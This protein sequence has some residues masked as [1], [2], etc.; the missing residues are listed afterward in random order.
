[1][2]ASG[3]AHSHARGASA[4]S[5]LGVTAVWPSSG[6]WP[7]GRDWPAASPVP[8]AA[9]ALDPG[10]RRIDTDSWAIGL[11]AL[12][13]LL[14]LS[15]PGSRLLALTPAMLLLG[16]AGEFHCA[17]H[18]FSQGRPH[19]SGALLI[20]KWRLAWLWGPWPWRRCCLHGTE[21]ALGGL[22]RLQRLAL[23]LCVGGDSGVALDLCEH[24]VGPQV[25]TVLLS[26]EE[27]LEVLVTRYW[28]DI[29]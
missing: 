19:G 1:M 25:R 20:A 5:T 28:R 4:A 17:G 10:R 16:E 8:L 21:I 29:S 12:A 9:A 14:A 26:C 2:G 6:S 11:L 23:L 15:W 7:P 27:W 22:G 3:S 13:T 18:T 24:G